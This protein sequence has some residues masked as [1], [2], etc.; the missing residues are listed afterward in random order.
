MCGNATYLQRWYLLVKGRCE[1]VG[2]CFSK[3][4]RKIHIF[5]F[6]FSI[7]HEC[8]NTVR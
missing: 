7:L 2:T 3:A 6:L 1:I 5:Y 4:L 8:L